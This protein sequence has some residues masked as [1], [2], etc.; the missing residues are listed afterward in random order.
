MSSTQQIMNNFPQIKGNSLEEAFVSKF[1]SALRT[2]SSTLLNYEK[3]AK[4]IDDNIIVRQ[5]LSSPDKDNNRATTRTKRDV[6][7]VEIAEPEKDKLTEESKITEENKNDEKDD[8]IQQIEKKET[9]MPISMVFKK[10][11]LTDKPHK[12]RKFFALKLQKI[13]RTALIDLYENNIPIDQWFHNNPFPKTHFSKSKSKEFIDEVK[14]GNDKRIKELLALDKYL[15][16]EYDHFKQTGF[17]WAAKR[18]LKSTL[19]ILVHHGKH[20]NLL[21][22]NKRTPLYLASK[23]NHFDVVKF[24]LEKGANPFLKSNNDKKP[25]DVCTEENIKRVLKVNMDN[26]NITNKWFDVL[27]FHKDV[28]M[29]DLVKTRQDD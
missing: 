9:V 24:L 6:K 20:L 13:L 22:L 17:H 5:H 8:K 29:V 12:E 28:K 11:S 14:L 26:I 2:N 25:I 16:F 21:D 18:G 19:E 7:S 10:L 4:K 27:K 15:V 23:N 1:K 3:C